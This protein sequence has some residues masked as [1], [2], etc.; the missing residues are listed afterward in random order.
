METGAKPAELSRVRVL[1]LT[2]GVP[3]PL[4]A[5]A[6]IRNFHL[7]KE[8]AG[9]AEIFLYCLAKDETAISDTSELQKLCR[10]VH[11][12]RPE[13]RSLWRLVGTI[14]AAL[15]NGIPWATWPFFYPDLA[16]QLRSTA[17]REAVGILQIEH[18]ILAGYACAAPES[19]R[20]VL[21][22]HNVGSVQYARMARLDVSLP[23]RAGFWV[24]AWLMK[25][26]ES[27]YAARFNHCIAVSSTDA[28]L[29]HRAHPSLAVSVVPNG[30][31]CRELQPLPEP[32]SGNDILFAGV[33]GYPPNTDAVRFFCR[34][35]LPR[36]R[37][38]VPD[39]RLLIVGQSPPPELRSLVTSE[40]VALGADVA[41]VVPYYRRA[42]LAVVPLR[43]GSGTRLKILEAM[44]LGRPVVSTSVGCEGIGVT[45]GR[46][47][48]IADGPEDFAVCVVSL[49]RDSALRA[50]LAACAR[51]TVEQSYD[52]QALAA[53]QLEVYFRLAPSTRPFR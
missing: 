50:A 38:E 26:C 5:G 39:A 20:T 24:K 40:A 15:K 4:N 46:D 2:Y 28:D 25:R 10:V 49:L 31:D 19:C 14:A 18:S 9:R 13:R 27:H 36:I 21:S 8:L 34:D 42:R 17:H 3:W 48:L 11:V 45:H 23:R 44:A 12:Y 32:P 1:L 37:R 16:A 6:R 30:V 43:A 47:I 35:I 51:G 7:I 33:L 52:W 53:R 41:G 29:L 22:F